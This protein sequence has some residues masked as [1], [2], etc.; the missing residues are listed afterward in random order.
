MPYH[1]LNRAERGV[2]HRMR[3]EGFSVA[4]MA[5]ALGRHRSTI[6]RELK[7][8]AVSTRSYVGMVAHTMY[9][10]R[11]RWVR[12]RPRQDHRALMQYV[13]SGLKRY[14][15]PEQIA[16]RL[17]VDYPNDRSM[18]ICAMTIYR[19][20][21][22]DRGGGGTLWQSLRQSRKKKRKRYRSNDQR[23]HLQGR[24][25]IE[26]RPAIVDEQGRY[27]DWEADTV[28]GNSR[29]AYLA[30]FVERK[31]LYLIARKMPD[32]T[33][34]SLNHA[35]CIAFKAIPKTLRK[36]ITVDNGKEFAAFSELERRLGPEIYFA[37]PYAAWERA[38]NENTNGLLRQFLPK[39][40]DLAAYSGQAVQ[41]A[42]RLLNNRPRK[43]LGYQTPNEVLNNAA[44]ALDM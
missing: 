27:G 18:R 39:K 8:N 28:C 38:I 5:A 21:A 4:E 10:K 22:R 32:H 14:W 9:R 33:A 37:H 42:V 11:Q 20:V 1:H 30:T 6:Y 34:K 16:G 15:S 25:F 44:V 41:K 7:R 31:S 24:T 40:T 3:I 23:G 29:K 43:K 35:A 26:D 17:R 13:H 2:I 36:T 12:H 19:H